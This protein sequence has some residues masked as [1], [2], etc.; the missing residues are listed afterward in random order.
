MRA[1]IKR[2]DSRLRMEQEAQQRRAFFLPPLLLAEG[3][4]II[5]KSPKH[6]EM[7][8]FFKGLNSK[9]YCISA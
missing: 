2:L 1:P 7:L 4:L 3:V 5:H 8:L 6:T 9:R